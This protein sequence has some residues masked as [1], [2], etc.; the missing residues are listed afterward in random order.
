[1]KR[2]ARNLLFV[3]CVLSCACVSYLLGHKYHNFLVFKNDNE[4]C[5]NLEYID[6]HFLL[7]K[8]IIEDGDTSAYKE[9][10]AKKSIYDKNNEL[11]KLSYSIYM[12]NKYNYPYASYQVYKIISSWNK[13]GI[14]TLDVDSQ[15]L[16]I[17]YLHKAASTDSSYINE[18]EK[19][20]STQNKL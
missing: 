14:D 10:L 2:L 16:A 19:V 7:K 13:A 4:M 9:Y 20:K 17:Y 3:L 18:F 1:M 15:K 6:E 12:S 5:N 11:D 8:H